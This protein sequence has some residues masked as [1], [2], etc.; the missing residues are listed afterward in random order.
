MSYRSNS[1]NPSKTRASFPATKQGK[2]RGHTQAPPHP[3]YKRRARR[4]AAH[5]QLEASSALAQLSY[6]AIFQTNA[7]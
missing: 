7:L 3:S 6:S 2:A 1:A 5:A 4:T